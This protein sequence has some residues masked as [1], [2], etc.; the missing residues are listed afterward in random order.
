MIHHAGGARDPGAGPSRDRPPRV[1]GAHRRRSSRRGAALRPALEQSVASRGS[2]DR[3]APCAVARARL[4]DRGSGRSG[5]SSIARS[6]SR[7]AGGRAAPGGRSTCI[8]DR[9]RDTR[10]LL[11]PVH[12]SDSPARPEIRMLAYVRAG[13]RSASA[14]RRPAGRHGSLDFF[15]GLGKDSHEIL[16]CSRN[17]ADLLDRATEIRGSC[18]D[19]P[20]GACDARQP[21]GAPGS[22][23]PEPRAGA[24][25]RT[26]PRSGVSFP[27][28]M[29]RN[30]T[31]QSPI[32]WIQRIC[33]L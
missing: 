29:R 15:P 33:S 18:R 27:R 21:G 2:R 32:G 1:A 19:R 13:T 20:I 6:G 16:C 4:P 28:G 23:L 26:I 24:Q 8:P 5:A 12:A 7:A 30:R 3:R 25:G 9:A 10:G 31:N 22:G 14:G 11:V 17:P